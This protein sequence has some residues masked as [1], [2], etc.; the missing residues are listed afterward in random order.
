LEALGKL[1]EHAE[2]VYQQGLD[3]GI[4][5]EIARCAMLVSRYS[6]MRCSA[7]L[8]NWLAF[9]TLRDDAKA[10]WE[11]QQFAGAGAVAGILT[12]LFPR[13]LTL[14]QEKR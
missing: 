1:Y 14:F 8:R 5:K 13:T 12:N 3:I 11:I 10:Q 6:R 2:Q 4:P 9:L 7:N